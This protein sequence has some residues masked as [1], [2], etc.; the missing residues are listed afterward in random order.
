M[1]TQSAPLSARRRQT[2][3]RLMDAAALVFAEKGVAGAS[4][5]EI[6]EAAGFTRGAFYSNFETKDELCV[7]LQRSLTERFLE[8]LRVAVEG[9]GAGADDPDRPDEA[10]LLDTAVD[11]FLAIQPS[12]REIVLLLMELQ[13]Y[14]LRHP[15]FAEI[16]AAHTADSRQVFSGVLEEALTRAGM[17]ISLPTEQIVDIL[18][19]VHNARQADSLLNPGQPDLLAAQLKSILGA[20]LIR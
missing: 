8:S 12:E 5:E 11:T 18:Q 2:R 6:C 4:V 15:H 19:A 10:A 17:R 7:A 16:Y 3:Q 1:S 20:L 14:A 13:L 9:M